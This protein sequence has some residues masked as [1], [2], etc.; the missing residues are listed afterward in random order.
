M[1]RV[2]YLEIINKF[3]AKFIAE[4]E[5]PKIKLLAKILMNYFVREFKSA[6]KKTDKLE[7]ACKNILLYIK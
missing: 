7:W 2:A 4:L 3:K 5:K 1:A 6:N